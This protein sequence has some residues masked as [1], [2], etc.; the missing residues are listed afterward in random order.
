M[1]APDGLVTN[2][3]TP[4]TAERRLRAPVAGLML[5]CALVVC[6]LDR[7]AAH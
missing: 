4:S 7:G 5:V 3:A 1:A 2:L 6:W